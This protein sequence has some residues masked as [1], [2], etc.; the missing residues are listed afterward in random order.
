MSA[1]LL[2]LKIQLYHLLARQSAPSHDRLFFT[3]RKNF[4]AR[5]CY[6]GAIYICISLSYV[7]WTTGIPSGYLAVS[8]CLVN[9]NSDKNYL[10]SSACVHALHYDAMPSEILTCISMLDSL[11]LFLQLSQ[12]LASRVTKQT[13]QWVCTSNGFVQKPAKHQSHITHNIRSTHFSTMSEVSVSILNFLK[14]CKWD[15]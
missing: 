2:S 12:C 11:S 14:S 3:N 7:Q 10:I 15:L 5:Y 9:G 1:L 4:T 6:G 13:T 8:H